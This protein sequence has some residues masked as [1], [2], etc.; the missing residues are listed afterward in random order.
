MGIRQI[1]RFNDDADLPARLNGVGFLDP[2]KG[3]RRCLELLKQ[4]VLPAVK[5][6]G[7]ELGLPGPFEQA[8]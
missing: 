7:K 2:F 4:E 8:P 3:I 6:M 5:E 1:F